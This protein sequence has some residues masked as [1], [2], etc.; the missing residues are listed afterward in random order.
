M[1]EHYP[2]KVLDMIRIILAYISTFWQYIK[3]F[4]GIL[5]DDETYKPLSIDIVIAVLAITIL[6]FIAPPEILL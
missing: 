4:I 3:S 6:V 5:M 2:F 1:L